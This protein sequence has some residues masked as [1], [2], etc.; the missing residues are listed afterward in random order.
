MSEG[1]P[2]SELSKV[3]TIYPQKL[4]NVDV[5][6][7]LDIETIPEVMQAIREVE[8]E[9]GETGRVLVRYSGTQQMCRV[10][11]EATSKAQT[12]ACCRKIAD[13]VSAKIGK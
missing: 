9:L 2:L 8:A 4:V 1:R 6:S 13:V 12:E 11:V 10:M 7:K 5:T 3:M